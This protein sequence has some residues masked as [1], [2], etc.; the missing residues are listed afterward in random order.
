MQVL[1][2]ANEKYKGDALLQKRY[3]M[4]FLTKKKRVNQ[5]E[6]PQ[7]YVEGSHATIIEPSVFE[8]VQKQMAVRHLG[9]NQHSSVSI[10]LSK[11]K[12]G[13]LVRFQ[14]VAFQ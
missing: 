10:F 1:T 6:M 3:M 9:K 7:F 13:E 11:I 8:A 14:G 2:R 5:G 4:D 12:C